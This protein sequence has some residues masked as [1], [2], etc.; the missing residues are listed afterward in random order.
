MCKLYIY[1]YMNFKITFHMVETD[2]HIC[3][4]KP[5]FKIQLPQFIMQKHDFI[6]CYMCRIIFV[7]GTLGFWIKN[8][9]MFLLSFIN[10]KN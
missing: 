4:G 6:A 5:I 8:Y 2:L 3:I 7:I 9:E 1:T 10:S